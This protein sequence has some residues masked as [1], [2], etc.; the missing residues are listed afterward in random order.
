MSKGNANENDISS[1]G[2][3]VSPGRKRGIL[4]GIAVSVGE[5][6]GTVPSVWRNAWHE[7]WQRQGQ[8]SS[9]T[10]GGDQQ[11][12]KLTS[13]QSSWLELGSLPPVST[14]DCGVSSCCSSLLIKYARGVSRQ[15][16]MTS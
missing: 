2:D 15:N 8:Q 10:H 13:Q 5:G 4:T 3:G 9:V 1:T 11:R 6:V 16:Y 12:V 7:G 14:T